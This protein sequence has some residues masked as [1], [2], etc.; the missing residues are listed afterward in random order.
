MQNLEIALSYLAAGLCVL[1]ANVQRKFAALSQWKEYQN[2]LPTGT[3]LRSWFG[4]G[5][6]GLCIVAGKVSGNLEMLDFDLE[7]ELFDRWRDIVAETSPNLL[8]QLVIERSQ[9]G[10]CHVIYRCQGEV[11]K[12]IKLAQRKITVPA[13]DDVVICGK[14][15]KPRR[16]KQGNWL[17]IITLIETRGEGG[18][19]LCAPSPGYT[20]SQGEFIHLPVLTTSQRDILLESAWALNE[21]VPDIVGETSVPSSP[22][23]GLR[24]GDDFNSRGDIRAILQAHGW[25]CVQSGDNERWRRPGKTDG[26]SATFN[27]KYF[28]VF[29]SNAS[30]F[31]PQTPYSPFVVYAM[32][33]H[34]GDYGRAAGS[35]SQKGFDYIH[36][37]KYVIDFA[38][39]FGLS[40]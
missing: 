30:P 20:L 10:G 12:S 24:P 28:Y 22:D 31:E 21:H 38:V 34:D 11:C 37:Y 8:E 33:E 29:T 1:P 27:G 35:L 26:W 3:E 23:S 19:F 25:K 15:Y 5:H 4:N 6:D 16:D 36:K 17:V 32:L 18:L 40:E 9:S 14:T 7:A 13:G 39:S 2:R